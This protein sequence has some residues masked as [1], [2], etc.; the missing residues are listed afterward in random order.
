MKL[1]IA[2]TRSFDLRADFI[3]ELVDIFNLKPTLIFSGGA[4]GVDRSGEWYAENIANRPFKIIMADWK[5]HGKAAGPIRNKRM[6][7]YADALLLIWDGESR[8]SKNMK[9]EMMK[10]KKP[11]Y[12][13]IL[14][15]P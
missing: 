10:L 15:E 14:R 13:V 12:E 9:E 2:G 7:E 1:I 5:N 4:S 6:A 8:G 3:R 11:I